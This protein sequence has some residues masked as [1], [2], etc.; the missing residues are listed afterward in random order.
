MRFLS[1]LSLS[2]QIV[3][4]LILGTGCGLFFGEYTTRIAFIGEAF[5]GLLQ[6]TVLPYIALAIIANIGRLAASDAKRFG[7]TIAIVLSIST[8]ITMAAVVLLPLCLPDRESASFFSTSALEGAV[9]IDFLRMF[10]PSNPFF[11]LANNIVPAVVTF[12]IASGAAIM[13]LENKEAVLGQLDFL[14]AALSRMN[15]QL[16]KLTPIGVFAIIANITGTMHLGEILQLRAYV[17]VN[18]AASLAVGY[19]VFMVLLAALTPFSYREIFKVSRAPVMTAL[20]TGKVLI[21]LPMIIAAAE[22]LFAKRLSDTTATSSY[23]R[24]ITPLVYPFPHAGKLLSLIFIPFAAWFVDVPLT[25]SDLPVFLGT[26]IFTMFGSPI[27]AMPF[28]LDMFKLPADLFQLFIASGVLVSRLGDLLGTIHLLFVSVLST[29]ILSNMLEI[30]VRKLLVS[31]TVILVISVIIGVGGK[32][33][34][35]RTAGEE[36]SKDEIVR[37]MH[38]AVHAHPDAVDIPESEDS[39]S[40]DTPVLQRIAEHGVV[41]VGY[42]PDNLPM[43]FVNASGELV[44]YDIDLAYLLAQQL[45]CQVEF[46]PIEFASLTKMLD[47]GEIDFAMSAI[48]MLPSRL[49]KMIF[50]RPYFNLTAAIVVLDHRRDEFTTRI[51]EGDFKGIRIGLV[52]TSEVRKLASALLPGAE[53]TQFSTFRE[54]CE[55]NGSVVD[56]AIWSAESGS[57]WTLLYPEYSVIP[58]RPLYQVPSGFAV[59]LENSAFASFLSQWLITI[60]AGH[61]DDQLYDHW[62]LGNNAEKSEPRWSII[63][64]VLHWVD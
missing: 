37:N 33:Y 2:T 43:S 6:M 40:A 1:R 24:G 41:R 56:G 29:A 12:C 27:A 36:Y 48:G 22:E 46:V 42:E 19:G 51:D 47:G 55:S 44:G 10:I 60:E 54:F 52:R 14:S 15:Q 28:L 21:V 26:G 57:A 38:S 63:R 5:V 49:T 34:L 20:V 18:L 53:F 11:S 32:A 39:L 59:S 31:T 8:A 16:M 45:D 9:E 50:T 4:G 58:L 25:V 17:F 23:V 7:A 30:N 61:Y 35:T 64:N 62:V 13:T 3:A